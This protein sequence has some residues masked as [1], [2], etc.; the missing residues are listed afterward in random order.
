MINEALI[1]GGDDTAWLVG[2]N[3]AVLAYLEIVEDR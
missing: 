3:G 2:D 1:I